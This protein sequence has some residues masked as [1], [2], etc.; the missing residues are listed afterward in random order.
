MSYAE[1]WQERKHVIV[2]SFI[3]GLIITILILCFAIF[4]ELLDANEDGGLTLGIALKRLWNTF[5]VVEGIKPLLGFVLLLI[6]LTYLFSTLKT[7][8]SPEETLSVV[9]NGGFA[10]ILS[11]F[12]LASGGALA[13]LFVPILMFAIIKVILYVTVYAVQ[14]AF[15]VVAFPFTTLFYF[16]MRKR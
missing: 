13:V 16:L 10:A 4:L 6:G 8:P 5:F 11:S 1:K 9:F 7:C 3:I 12:S 2:K 15:S 14:F